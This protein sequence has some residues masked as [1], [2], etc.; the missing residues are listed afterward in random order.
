MKGPRLR[1][2]AQQRW[3]RAKTGPAAGGKGAQNRAGRAQGGCW[4]ASVCMCAQVGWG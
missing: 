2:G 4:G 3:A 1:G